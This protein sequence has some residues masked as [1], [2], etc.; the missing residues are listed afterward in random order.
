LPAR[1]DTAVILAAG[2]GGR[3]AHI[4]PCKPLARCLGI[5][6]LEHSVRTLMAAGIRR[7]V[8]VCG[9]RADKVSA[10]AG[11]LGRRLGVEICIIHHNGWRKGN[12]SSA[13]AARSAVQGLFLL[14]M[15]DHLFDA[16]ILRRL[17]RTDPP[18]DGLVLAVDGHLENPLVDMEDVTRVKRNGKHIA[19]IGKGL[20]QFDAFDTGAFL[21]TPG[22]FTALADAV[23]R[24]EGSLSAAVIRLA[25]EK[26]ALTM[27]VSG[28]FW[29]DVDDAATMAQASR[30]L[31]ARSGN[32]PFRPCV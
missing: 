8:L 9:Y 2:K 18:D 29:I 24:N 6:L 4:T 23:A 28:A 22:L 19:D 20:E 25:V 15:C 13:L 1:V 30:A 3:L 5:P 14:V 16:E 26:R 10:F 7:I 32:D 27:D 12:G 31:T 17:I 11:R 21:C